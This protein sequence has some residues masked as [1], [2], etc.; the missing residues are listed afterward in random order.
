MYL[1]PNAETVWLDT[2]LDL[3][4]EDNGNCNFSIQ[5]IKNSFFFLFLT[6]LTKST[7]SNDQD[8]LDNKLT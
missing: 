3:R 2:T 8:C 6:N 4:K 7:T 1:D 5:N